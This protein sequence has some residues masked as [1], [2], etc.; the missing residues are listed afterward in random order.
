MNIPCVKIQGIIENSAEGIEKI[1]EM[2][3]RYNMIL[4]DKIILDIFHY[5][6]EIIVTTKTRERRLLLLN[7]PPPDKGYYEF[8]AD[9]DLV[10]K[11]NE[12]KY[13]SVKRK[14]FHAD[15]YCFDSEPEKECF[16]QYVFSDKVKEVYFTGMFT[17]H[18]GELA[19]QYIDPETH[20]L[21]NYY[22]DFVAMMKD[23]T[24][25]IIEVKGDN[26]LDDPVVKA[27]QAAAIE[28]ATE[29]NNIEYLVMPGNF[30]LQHNVFDT[31]KNGEFIYGLIEDGY[32]SKMTADS[33]EMCNE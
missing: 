6:Y 9:P 8:H 28:L 5:L 32:G 22:P 7:E 25:Q 31:P 15:I 23:N 26:K 17:S 4:Y 12:V 3:N 2:V 1:V 10:V 21:R 16:N 27:K 20:S 29:S 30:I 13:N 11:E 18:Q 19:I 24:V 14:S 33:R